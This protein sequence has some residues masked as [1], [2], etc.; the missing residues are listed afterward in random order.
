ML[1]A[2]EI[3]MDKGVSAFVTVMIYYRRRE[4]IS[5]YTAKCNSIHAHSTHTHVQAIETEN[6]YTE[7]PSVRPLLK[8]AC[9]FI[10]AP[11]YRNIHV[12]TYDV[13]F[14]CIAVARRK[15]FGGDWK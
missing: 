7:N 4:T 15:I 2:V 3:A 12:I 5:A 10:T 8:R 6:N 13:I 14:D 9:K 11:R 1:F